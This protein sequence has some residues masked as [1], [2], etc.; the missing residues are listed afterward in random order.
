[1]QHQLPPLPY[2]LDA[3][4][5]HI[6][7]ETMEFHYGKHHKAY[8][9]KLNELI[10]GKPQAEMSLEEI[11]RNS[12]GPIFNNAAQAW[13]HTFFWQC[14][15]PDGGKA[16][17]GTLTQAIDGS[18]GSLEKFKDEFSSAAIAVF[19]SGWTWLVTDAAGK[20][21]IRSTQNADT[22]IAEEGVPLLTCD[23]W[24][25]AYYIDYRNARPEFV[26]AFWN[27]VNWQFAARNYENRAQQH[28]RVKTES[29]LQG[30]AASRERTGVVEK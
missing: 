1:M 29:G 23:V 13:N 25:H 12:A 4:E 16:P 28:S 10:K 11:V 22:P 7:R 3:L 5:P 20:L 18:F 2:P 9:D 14:M 6:S 27:V 17:Q 26:K 15:S 30:G 8:V 24:E 21:A 19:G